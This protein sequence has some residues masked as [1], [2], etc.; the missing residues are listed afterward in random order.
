MSLKEFDYKQF[1][2]EKGERLG[3]GIAVAL[4]V[5]MLVWSLFMPS[6]GFFSGSPGEKAKELNGGTKQLEDALRNKQ[7]SANDLPEKGEGRLI[8]LDTA[9]LKP[10]YYETTGWFE[11]VIHEDKMRR[12]PKILNVVEAVGEVAKMPIDT[13]LFRFDSDSIKVV[14]L[15]KGKGGSGQNTLRMRGSMPTMQGGGSSMYQQNMQRQ[16]G[17]PPKAMGSI[18]QAGAAVD[19]NKEHEPF[20]IPAEQWDPQGDLTARQPRPLRMT[21]IG[22]SF[23]YRKQLE[24][25]KRKLKCDSLEAVLNE[26]IDDGDKKADAF[27][28][29]GVEV[30]RREVDADGKPIKNSDWTKLD[31]KADYQFWLKY[32]YLPPEPEDDKYYAIRAQGLYAPMLRVF[33]TDKPNVNTLQGGLTLPGFA[34]PGMPRPSAATNTPTEEDEPKKKYPDLVEKLPKLQETLENLKKEDAKKIATPRFRPAEVANLFDLDAPAKGA[35]AAASN[36]GKQNV[37][38]DS[39]YPDYVM[40]RVVDVNNIQPGKFYRYRLKVKMANPNYKRKDVASPD[41]KEAEELLS[42]QWYELPNTVSVPP[43]TLYYAVDETKL[44]SKDDRAVARK[45]SQ[46]SAQFKLLSERQSSDQVAFQLH[47]WVE[48]T[49]IKSDEVLV[50]DWVIAD[51]V[52]VSRGEYIGRK[53]RVDVPVWLYTRN[54]FILPTEEKPR[55]KGAGGSKNLSTGV[56]VD[57]SNDAPENNAI[58][59]DFE[60]GAVQTPVRDEAAV[61]VLML[62]PDGKLLV[63]NSVTDANDQDRTARRT[64]VFKRIQETREGRGKE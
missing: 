49:T 46:L 17:A 39:V 51:R 43:E 9:Y 54:A 24:E 38:P 14:I 7:P 22:A 26:Q 55:K 50:G 42:D 58:L 10:D 48:K 6:K 19:D 30:E 1:L 44:M 25:H 11:P 21:I 33:H 63:R 52:L 23:P 59:V 47:R 8:K 16:F 32:T 35:D 41:Y 31:L 13:Y 60:G 4:M 20:S 29:L 64:E 45:L 62:A 61:Q 40:V 28:F 3:L 15:E 56:E 27:R 57:F 37:D 36:Q 18:G 5:F 34:P 12:Q 53:V 2:L